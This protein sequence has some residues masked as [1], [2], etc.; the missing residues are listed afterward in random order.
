MGR[1][2][3]SIEYS[4]AFRAAKNH[5][6]AEKLIFEFEEL[7]TIGSKLDIKFCHSFPRIT[8]KEY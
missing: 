3:E 6:L 2:F 4:N 8:G 1:A 5:P 7:R